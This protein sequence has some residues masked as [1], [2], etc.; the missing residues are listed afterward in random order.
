M[1]IIYLSLSDVHRL[2]LLLQHST[3]LRKFIE[4]MNLYNTAQVDYRDGC[5]K[6]LQRQMEISES[7]NECA[8]PSLSYNAPSKV[9]Y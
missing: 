2:M 3:I 4:V 1:V 6:R 7:K 8:L 5:K 9:L